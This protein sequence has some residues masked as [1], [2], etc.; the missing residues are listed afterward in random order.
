MAIQ[1]AVFVY[2]YEHNVF[3][4]K[5]IKIIVVI[6]FDLNPDFAETR[7]ISH[8]DLPCRVMSANKIYIYIIIYASAHNI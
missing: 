5:N 4:G 6:R 3:F 8:Y 7:R 2:S 1:F